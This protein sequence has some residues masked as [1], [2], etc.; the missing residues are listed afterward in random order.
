M[1][2]KP[3]DWQKL[4]TGVHCGIQGT[5]TQERAFAHDFNWRKGCVRTHQESS[6]LRRGGEAVDTR[7][8]NIH[9]KR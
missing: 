5:G 1:V 9:A 6:A 2:L 8:D 3:I 4:D 7:R